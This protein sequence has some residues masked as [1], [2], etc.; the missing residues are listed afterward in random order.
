MIMNQ[1]Q[2]CNLCTKVL[3]PSKATNRWLAHQQRIGHCTFQT[4]VY[5]HQ[6]LNFCGYVSFRAVNLIL[7]GVA[8][9]LKV[10]VKMC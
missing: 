5:L 7:S 8:S 6:T 1:G 10:Q 9:T 2:R 4:Y 3:M